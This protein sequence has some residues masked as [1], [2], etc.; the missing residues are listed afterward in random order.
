[1]AQLVEHHLAK[2]RVA[3]SNPVVRSIV[4]AGRLGVRLL[5]AGASILVVGG[6]AR[7]A[8]SSDALVVAAA[9]DLRDAFGELAGELGT[10]DLGEV[11][12][13]FGSSGMLREQ[14]LNGAPYDVY[15]SANVGFV[16]EVIAAGM[17]VSAQPTIYAIG[18]LA[19]VTSG[20]VELTSIAAVVTDARRIVIAQPKHA[21]YGVAAREALQTL[22]LWDTVE[23]R[24]VYAD[25]V[26]D[27]VRIVQSGEVDAGI[28]ARSLVINDP[29]LIVDSSLHEPLRQAAVVLRGPRESRARA[30]VDALR[31]DTV[32][33]LM[34]R[35][36]FDTDVAASGE[37]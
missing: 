33:A 34:V 1:M 23:S 36:G 20:E 5:L 30:F 9:S 29:H 28:V 21:P 17:S 6:C 18:S 11:T 8:D 13:V 31:T 2:V 16:D 4:K 22:G 19:V 10:T 14:I 25:N 27:A 35:Y 7:S 24:I 15:V 3:G 12:F 37:E 26:A 32:R